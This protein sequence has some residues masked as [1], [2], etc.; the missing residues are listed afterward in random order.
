VVALTPVEVYPISSRDML[1]DYVE[2]HPSFAM[3][4]IMIMAKRVDQM[5]E[6]YLKTYGYLQYAKQ[7]LMESLH[8]RID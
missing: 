6:A 5:K 1:A 8:Q 3:R 4:M 2:I 7:V